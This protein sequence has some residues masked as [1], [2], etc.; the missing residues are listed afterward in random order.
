MFAVAAVAAQKGR[1]V[2]TIDITGAFRHASM[3]PTGIDV[4]IRID[5]NL[6]PILASI[7][8]I[9]HD[10]L[11]DD[12][13]ITVRLDKALYGCVEAAKLWYDELCGTLKDIGF[14]PNPEETCVFNKGVGESQVTIVLHVDDL[15]VTARDRKQLHHVADKLQAKYKKVQQHSG[16]IVSYLGLTMDFSTP[17]EVRITQEGYI[18]TLLTESGVEGTA[19]TPATEDLFVVRDGIELAS[20]EDS[21]WFHRQTARL[22]YLSKRTKPEILVATAFLTT[23]VTKC[24]Q[25]DLGK[26]RRL[27]RYVRS[28]RDRGLCLKPGN[29]GCEVSIYIDAAYGVHSDCKSHTGSAIA[30]GQAILDS[31]SKRQGI[32]TKSS[33]E[34]E[35]VGA[36]DEL[37]KGF[38]MRRFILNQGHNIGPV[39]LYQ[40][41]LSTMAL[42]DKGKS[43]SGRTRHVDIRYFWIKER[44]ESG[45]VIVKHMGT[46]NMIADAMTKPLQ[47]SE[48]T[49]ERPYKLG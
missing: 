21:K 5:K 19:K 36:S 31:S 44:I 30:V 32:V 47:G 16:P 40:D 22:L 23:R 17:G 37:G 6:A 28:A 35:L 25:D 15:L 11:N 1:E 45:E 3:F 27:I 4:Y 24:D 12:G 26:L 39:T 46:T 13:T 38:H 33:T 14:T 49:R 41:N 8:G 20:E 9:Y 29:E 43:T 10:M 2:M 18:D 34:A 7:D 42:I 48:F